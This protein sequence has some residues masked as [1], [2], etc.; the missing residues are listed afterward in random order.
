MLNRI[1]SILFVLTICVGPFAGL[2]SF[3]ATQSGSLEVTKQK[4][5]CLTTGVGCGSGHILL[6]ALGRM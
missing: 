4:S 2:F 6:P 3:A 1:F 5:M